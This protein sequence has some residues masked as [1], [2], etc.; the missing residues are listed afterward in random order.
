MYIGVDTQHLQFNLAA[1]KDRKRAG[2]QASQKKRKTCQNCEK[3][4]NCRK[5]SGILVL[6]LLPPTDFSQKKDEEM[7]GRR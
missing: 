4:Q 1:E 3:Q 6:L 5:Y 2:R 7:V